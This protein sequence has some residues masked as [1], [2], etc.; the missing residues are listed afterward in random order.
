MAS[1]TLLSR[2]R[3]QLAALSQGGMTVFLIV[4]F[5]QII[6]MIG[7]GMTCFAQSITVYTDL[8]GSIANLGI[9]AILAQLPGILLSPI[10]GV[11]ADRYDRRW[12]MIACDTVAALATLGL[13]LLIISGVYQIW[14]IYVIVIIISIANQISPRRTHS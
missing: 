8:G 14:H 5:G 12:M 2:S 6:S 9:L 13:R 11:L 4:W 3:Q 7:S 10:A 1:S